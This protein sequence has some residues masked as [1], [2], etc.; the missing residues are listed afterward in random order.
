MQNLLIAISII[1]ISLLAA[2]GK[3]SRNMRLAGLGIIGALLG[4]LSLQSANA[5]DMAP[6]LVCVAFVVNLGV[7]YFTLKKS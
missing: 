1:G 7:I 3:L 4:F 2:W 6:L 5:S